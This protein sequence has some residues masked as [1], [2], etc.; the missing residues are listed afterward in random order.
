MGLAAVV[1]HII[2]LEMGDRQEVAVIFYLTDINQRNYTG[3]RYCHHRIF[4]NFF[5]EEN[6]TKDLNKM[7]M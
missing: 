5:W 2:C 6:N 1:L 3:D 4:N 7:I